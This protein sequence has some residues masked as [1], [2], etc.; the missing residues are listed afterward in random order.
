MPE[1]VICLETGKIYDSIA[2]TKYDGFVPRYVSECCRGI[3]E[4]Y[5]NYHWMFYNDYLLENKEAV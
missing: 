3:R 4:I 2:S 1:K 5:K